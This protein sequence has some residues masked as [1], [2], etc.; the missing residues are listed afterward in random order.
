MLVET[1]GLDN[2]ICSNDVKTSNLYRSW[3]L[4]VAGQYL[5]PSKSLV[6][7]VHLQEQL[8]Q[9]TAGWLLPSDGQ[10]K[11]LPALWPY[12]FP[13]L[14]QETAGPLLLHLDERQQDIGQAKDK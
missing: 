13:K 14:G 1:A 2:F 5:H 4:V 7:G 10:D 11:V 8:G 12:V 3:Q 6:P 9:H